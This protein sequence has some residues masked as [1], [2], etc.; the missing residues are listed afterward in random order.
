M[1]HMWADLR[2]KA[3][4]RGMQVGQNTFKATDE[5]DRVAMEI[6]EKFRWMAGMVQEFRNG[7]PVPRGTLKFIKGK[8]AYTDG[9]AKHVR[10]KWATR[11]AAVVQFDEEGREQA[12][13]I[14]L[15]LGFPV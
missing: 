12:W 8:V 13:A 7:A 11:A 15:P 4:N 3:H 2:P 5:A 9:S 10:T 14:V 6:Q 1:P